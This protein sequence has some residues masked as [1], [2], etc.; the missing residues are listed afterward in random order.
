M[1]LV[2]LV[3]ALLLVPTGL[4]IRAVVERAQARAAADAVALA[5]AAGGRQEADEVARANGAR[6]EAYRDEGDRV[7]VTVVVGRHRATAR[8]ART[9]TVERPPGRPDD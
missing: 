3:A 4:V 8:A 2:L 1:A 7:E 5:G 9:V 6:V